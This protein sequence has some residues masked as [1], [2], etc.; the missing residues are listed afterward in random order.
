[1][2]KITKIITVY[3]DGST[4]TQEFY[5]APNPLPIPI[6]HCPKCNIQLNAVMGYCCPNSDCPT[7]MG[8]I[9]CKVE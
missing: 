5:T 7:G 6:N 2:K 3:D 9:M 8:P 4:T 1:M